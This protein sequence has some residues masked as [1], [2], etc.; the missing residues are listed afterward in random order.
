MGFFVRGVVARE[1]LAQQ[2]ATLFRP[3][4][5]AV[6][7]AQGFALVPYTDQVH[8]RLLETAADDTATFEPFWWLSTVAARL[9]HEL[10]RHG[11]LAYV[12]AEYFGG[13]GTQHAVVWREGSTAY[14]PAGTQDEAPST[15]GDSPISRALHYIG[16][17]RTPAEHD[18]FAALGLGRHRQLE[19]W[20][21]EPDAER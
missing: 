10:S 7:L 16:A 1:D 9:L 8:D 18:E 19:D 15:R 3:D 21:N 5:R 13:I 20:L 2:V 17:T 14:G 6:P 11:A 4:A 12:E